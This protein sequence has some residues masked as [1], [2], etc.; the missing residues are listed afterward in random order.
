MNFALHTLGLIAASA[1]AG[2]E[3]VGAA[4]DAASHTSVAALIGGTLG[5]ISFLIT[6]SLGM[7][8]MGVFNRPRHLVVADYHDDGKELTRISLRLENR[9]NVP[10]IFESFEILHPRLDAGVFDADG[11]FL[12][13]GGAEIV[14]AGVGRGLEKSRQEFVRIDRLSQK[15][16]LQPHGARTEFFEVAAQRDGSPVLVFRDSFGNRFHCDASGAH[17]GRYQYPHRLAYLHALGVDP[18]DDGVLTERSLLRRWRT[19][20]S[21]FETA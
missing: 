10:V 1:P 4:H 20:H 9:G 18:G 13:N 17:A 5:V 11:N 6:I 3:T 19:E 8:Q 21:R 16:S 12:L 15:I 7:V 2:P 14:D